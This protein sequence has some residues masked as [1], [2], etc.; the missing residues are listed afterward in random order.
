MH[1]VDPSIRTKPPTYLFSHQIFKEQTRDK[2]KRSS[3]ISLALPARLIFSLISSVGPS[4]VPPPKA[5]FASVRGYL[6][7]HGRLRKS[8]FRGCRIFFTNGKNRSRC[9][10][11]GFAGHHGRSIRR[12]IVALFAGGLPVATA[13]PGVVRPRR[14]RRR[15]WRPRDTPEG[16]ESRSDTGRAEAARP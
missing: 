2:I 9:W 10:G 1:N 15:G 11:F 5:S 12:N 7:T 4:A 16:A 3:P 6:R 14:A 8:F 13:G